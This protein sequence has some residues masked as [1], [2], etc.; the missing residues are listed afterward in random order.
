[1]VLQKD[2]E[3]WSKLKWVLHN[4]TSRPFFKEIWFCNLGI[5]IGFEQN[6]LGK[7]YLRPVIII[8]KF[9]N[10]IFWALPLTRKSK[11]SKYYFTFIFRRNEL[12]TVILSQVRLPDGKRLSHKIGTLRSQDFASLIKKLKAL[13]P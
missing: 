1:M 5:N 12:S 9:N 11:I 4:K 7:S 3:K 6:G 2:F 8:R 13:L 10:Q